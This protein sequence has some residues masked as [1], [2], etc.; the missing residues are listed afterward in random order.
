[1]GASSLE[2]RGFTNRKGGH[3]DISLPRRTRNNVLLRKLDVHQIR[4]PEEEE[5]IRDE[6]IWRIV[7]PEAQDCEVCLE[8]AIVSSNSIRL[9]LAGFLHSYQISGGAGDSASVSGR[10]SSV[11]P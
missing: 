1:L 6:E 7:A 2:C 11:E 10:S 9:S 4:R 5:G 8:N 3:V